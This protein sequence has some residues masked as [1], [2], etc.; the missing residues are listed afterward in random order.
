MYAS[1]VLLQ[2]TEKTAGDDDEDDGACQALAGDAL[3]A[4]LASRT[5]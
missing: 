3:V 5:G 2:A 1:L 4:L